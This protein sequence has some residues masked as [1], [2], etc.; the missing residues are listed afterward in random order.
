MKIAIIGSGISGLAAAYRLDQEHEIHVFEASDHIGGHTWT[1]PVEQDGTVWPVDTGFVVFN[2]ETYPGLCTLF[3]ELDIEYRET[4]MSFSVQ[5]PRTGFAYQGSGLGGYYATPFSLL[6][7]AHH[8]MLRDITRFHRDSRRFMD[9]GDQTTTL[10]EWIGQQRY[11]KNFRERYLYPIGSSIWSCA[12]SEFAN[13]PARFVIE[14]ML[15]HRMLQIRN[16]PVWR[17]VVGGSSSYV[18]KMQ[19]RMRASFHP[20]TPVQSVRRQKDDVR[21][22][23]DGQSELGFD[24]VIMACHADQSL[25]LVQDPDPVETQLLK[26][27][28]YAS[29][30]VVLHTDS[31][32]LPRRRRARA[33]WNYLLGDGDKPA[34]ITYDMSR[35]QGLDSRDPFCI[36]LN[37]TELINPDRILR[38]FQTSH[39]TYHEMRADAQ[40]RHDELINLD[41]ISYCGAYWGYGF[42][43][44]GYQSGARVARQ[45]LASAARS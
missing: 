5:C 43:E 21:I 8:L 14:F 1:I 25:E 39:P 28:P 26:C 29:N 42:H 18:T 31:D 6:S 20:A 34:T 19:Q 37:S 12:R 40:G 7:P 13:F 36:T 15:N 44:D 27:F 2:Q 22:S 3:E 17:T 38:R 23:I 16:R 33:S 24:H 30:D 10:D 35:L 41:G 4:S 45:L 11:G 32:L 9:S